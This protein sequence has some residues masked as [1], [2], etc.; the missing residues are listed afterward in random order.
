MPIALKK[1]CVVVL[2]VKLQVKIRF[3]TFY[4]LLELLYTAFAFN[5]TIKTALFA[6]SKRAIYGAELKL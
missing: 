1:Y 4:W 3:K 2:N 5:G 6:R